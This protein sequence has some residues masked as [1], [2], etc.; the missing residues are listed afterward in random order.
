I[1]FRPHVHGIPGKPRNHPESILVNQ[2]VSFMG[3]ATK[4]GHNYLP[5][6]GLFVDLFD[7]THWQLIEAKAAVTR[8]KMRMALGQLEDYRRFYFSRHPSLAVLLPERPT[9]SCTELLIDNHVSVIW[10]TRNGSF[11]TLRWQT[12]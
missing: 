2:Y 11:R 1:A 5:V 9:S 12:D 7:Q 6:P 10:R 3:A 8:D 4:F